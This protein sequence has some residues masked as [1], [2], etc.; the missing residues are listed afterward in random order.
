MCVERELKLDIGC[1][2]KIE[3]MRKDG[4][5]GVDAHDFGQRYVLDIREGLPFEDSSID[6]ARAEH[7]LE[8]LT[9]DEAS[10]FMNEM[11][12]VLKPD[13]SFHIVVPY[14]L[15]PK[16]YGFSHRSFWTVESFRDLGYPDYWTIYGLRRWKLIKGV[17]NKRGDVHAFL[18][19]LDKSGGV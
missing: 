5:V 14:A 16:S 8:H 7:F 13:A 4:F 12:R 2:K 19:P 11:W 10:A 1:G 9:R 18:E 3:I 15:D 17:L 6:E